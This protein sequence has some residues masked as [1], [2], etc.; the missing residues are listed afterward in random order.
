[1]GVT[2]LREPRS[3]RGSLLALLGTSTGLL[4]VNHGKPQVNQVNPGKPGKP[5]K[6]SKLGKPVNLVNLVTLVNLV[7]RSQTGWFSVFHKKIV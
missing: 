5:G 6:P 7:N 2:A 3:G 4:Q 1:M